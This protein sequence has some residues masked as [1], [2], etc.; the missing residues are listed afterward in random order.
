[1]RL[2][3]RLEGRLEGI[4]VPHVTPF[5][6]S[7][8][9][10]GNALRKLIS[11]WL[12]SGLHGLVSLGSNGEVVYL[13]RE[14]RRKVLEIVVDEVNGKATVIAG[15][16]SAGTRE[17]IRLTRDAL[18]VGDVGDVGVDAVLIVTP[19]YFKPSNREL[20][21]HYA[22]II[23]AV[24]I[25]VI[26]YNV[27]KFTGLDMDL[28]VVVKLVDEF[29]QIVGIKESG[30]SLGRITEL[31]RLVGNRISILA[32]TGDLILPTLLM[33]GDGAIVGVANVAPK[34]CANLYQ[35]FKMGEIERAKDLQAKLTYLDE[36]LVKKLNQLSAIKE[37]LNILTL[38]AG[39]PRLPALPL[40]EDERN[41][42][43]Q[44]LRFVGLK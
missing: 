30:G 22:R 11:F 13:S 17:T 37:A 20:F 28:E 4:F 31:V 27:P 12:D 42:I 3:C 5:T 10:D 29:S 43:E 9:I 15:T 21:E 24:D 6:K 14:E 25:P 26:L 39:F 32:G 1:M 38:P 19:Y 40:G 7:G 18:D 2:K 34:L 8:E 16:G 35:T 36:V 44:V 41:E 33:G 23:Q